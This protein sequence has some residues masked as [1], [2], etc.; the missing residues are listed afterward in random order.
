MCAIEL[1]IWHINILGIV[2]IIVF[3]C[4]LC[5]CVCVSLFFVVLI[6]SVSYFTV[7]HILE[8]FSFQIFIMHDF[9][10]CSV[11]F[12]F[13]ET[14]FG[15]SEGS[16]SFNFTIEWLWKTG[17]YRF[18]YFCMEGGELSAQKT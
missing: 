4:L 7:G 15:T 13:F 6:T 14:V 1:P 16:G 18:K 17:K 5:V 11:L 8:S 2:I 9:Q 10:N 3:Q 12:I